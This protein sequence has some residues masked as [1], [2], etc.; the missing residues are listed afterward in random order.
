MLSY[1]F[2]E[3]L[4]SLTWLLYYTDQLCTIYKLYYCILYSIFHS[5]L[6]F[7]NAI[8]IQFNH[9]KLIILFLITKK[10]CNPRNPNTNP[11]P[12]QHPFPINPPLF[13]FLPFTFPHLINN[14]H[15]M[16]T[17]LRKSSI[18]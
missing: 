14:N 17:K 5:M 16:F 15:Q 18:L 2:Y 3:R 6:Q 12:T 4:T 9:H 13:I 1:F 7:S 10:Q 11:P 8:I